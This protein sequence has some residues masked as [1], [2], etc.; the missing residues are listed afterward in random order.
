[1]KLLYTKRSPYARKVRILALEKGIELDCVDEDLLNKS[2]QLVEAN[3]LGRVPAL[4]LDD[5]EVLS[6]SSIICEYLESIQPKPSFYPKNEKERL[7]IVNYDLIAKGLTEVTVSIFYEKMRHSDN[8]H[9]VFVQTQESTIKRTLE[10]FEAQISSFQDFHIAA[11][12]LLS[13]IG[14][15]EFRMPHLWPQDSCPKLKSWYA[16]VSQRISVIETKPVL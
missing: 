2:Q 7:R 15:L 16:D 12:S 4:I 1:M 13:A 14:Y 6:D 8:P 11:V 9:T 10:Y 3:P 5:G